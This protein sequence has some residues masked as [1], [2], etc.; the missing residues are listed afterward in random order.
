MTVAVVL[1]TAAAGLVRQA[2]PAGASYAGELRP[3]GAGYGL[4]AG[5][6]AP[7]LGWA[8]RAAGG[9]KGGRIR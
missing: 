1:C 4:I 5:A 2:T 7:T 6:S 3:S 8:I 9:A